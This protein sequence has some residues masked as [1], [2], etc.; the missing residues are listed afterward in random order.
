MLVGLAA[1]VG[2][3]WPPDLRAYKKLKKIKKN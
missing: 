1:I 2:L 3:A